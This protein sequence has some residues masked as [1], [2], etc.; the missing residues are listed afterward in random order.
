MKVIFKSRFK[1]GNS[2]GSVKEKRQKSLLSHTGHAG[3]RSDHPSY[4][5]REM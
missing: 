5:K 3:D 2:I 1:K 4:W